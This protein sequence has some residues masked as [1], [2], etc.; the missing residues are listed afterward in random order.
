M[1][2][3]PE[4]IGRYKVTGLLGSGSMGTV[5][6]AF[7]PDIH[8]KVAIKLIHPDLLASEKGPDRSIQIRIEAQAA[9]R[10][11]H[12][13]IVTLFDFAMQ[14]ARPYFVMEHVEGATLKDVMLCKER[15]PP[16]RAIPLMT[17]IL[18]GLDAAHKLG[19]VHRDVKP[20]NILI[21]DEDLVKV[22]DFGIASLAQSDQAGMPVLAGT[23]SYMSPEQSRGDPVDARADL[24]S[25]G[26]IFYQMLTGRRLFGSGSATEIMRRVAHNEH[27]SLDVDDVPDPLRDV[28]RRALD[29]D[30]ERRFAS[31]SEMSQALQVACR[32]HVPGRMSLTVPVPS[33]MPFDADVLAGVED[34]LTRYV[35]PIAGVLVRKASDK[36]RSIEDLCKMLADAIDDPRANEAFL[37]DVSP[38]LASVQPARA[39]DAEV[40]T[41]ILADMRAALAQYVG[42]IAGTLLRRALEKGLSIDEVWVELAD[43]IEDAGA[44]ARF[45]SHR[46]Q[47]M[48]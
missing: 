36:A 33:S 3:H 7:D 27:P 18:D 46:H 10:C 4:H 37:T 19:I 38:Y 21:N 11:A 40:D 12:P 5:Y 1:D 43:Q 30:R 28:L 26:V 6:A 32:P 24:F 8:R 44:R 39:T 2:G 41:E 13:N 48:R 20:A 14:D 25:A 35:G 31:A 17:Q 22:T 9:G 45:L 29:T 23:P 47:C 15:L 34:R 42:P 16:S